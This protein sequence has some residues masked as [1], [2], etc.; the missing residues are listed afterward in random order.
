MNIDGLNLNNVTTPFALVISNQRGEA[1]DALP[2]P[3]SNELPNNNNNPDHISFYL[4]GVSLD[5]QLRL[6]LSIMDQLKMDQSTM[7]Y[8]LQVI[9]LIA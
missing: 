9:T 7:D 3:S 8:F 6:I 4:K 2:T 1:P 5:V